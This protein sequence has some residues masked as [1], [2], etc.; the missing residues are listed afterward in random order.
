MHPPVTT[1]IDQQVHVNGVP[2]AG[3]HILKALQVLNQ[4]T[5]PEASQ[6]H[7][8]TGMVRKFTGAQIYQ[9]SAILEL[10][11]DQATSERDRQRLAEHSARLHSLGYELAQGKSEEPGTQIKRIDREKFLE[12]NVMMLMA[13]VSALMFQTPK[14]EAAIGALLWCAAEENVRPVDFREFISRS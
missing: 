8:N 4:R 11:G 5:F 10:M 13:T 3:K 1:V 2:I 6:E 9:M 14:F 12:A 7:F